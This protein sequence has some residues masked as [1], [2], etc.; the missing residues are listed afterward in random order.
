MTDG[1]GRW[2]A[3]RKAAAIEAV[4]GGLTTI[5]ELGVSV[6]E[7]DAWSRDYEARGLA[8]LHAKNLRRKKCPYCGYPLTEENT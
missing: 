8:G 6:E 1:S 5:E 2:T 3:R 7:F 4:V